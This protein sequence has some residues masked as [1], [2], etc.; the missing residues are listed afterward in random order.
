MIAT[1]IYHLGRLVASQRTRR[2]ELDVDLTHAAMGIVMAIM[3]VGSLT[4][5]ASRWWAVA[6]A[7]PTLWFGWRSLH[8][9]VLEGARAVGRTLPQALSCT[10]MLYMLIPAATSAAAQSPT[11]KMAGMHMAGMAMSG[12]RDDASLARG[13][14]LDILLVVAM[15]GV[16][17]WT[18]TTLARRARSS[19]SCSRDGTLTPTLTASCHL[20]MNV[21]TVYMLML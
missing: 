2:S 12:E 14:V 13:Q 1:A 19:A 6:F 18:A 3:L 5:V 20:A 21:T 8:S 11:T 16:A 15:L 9:C 7:V 10:V 17:T 4:P